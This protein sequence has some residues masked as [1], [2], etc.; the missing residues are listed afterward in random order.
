MDIARPI[1]ESAAH[2]S[3]HVSACEYRTGN[4]VDA[5]GDDLW[6]LVAAA[7]CSDYGACATLIRR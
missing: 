4:A 2:H 5:A 6:T 1:T 3:G 7:A